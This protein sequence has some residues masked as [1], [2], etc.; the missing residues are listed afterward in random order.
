MRTW[1]AVLSVMGVVLLGCGCASQ[2]SAADE[3]NAQ[4]ENA[5]AEGVTGSAPEAIRRCHRVC[6]YD[7]RLRRRICRSVCR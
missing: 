4:V 6:R 2:E 7:H 1:A 5:Q 3:E